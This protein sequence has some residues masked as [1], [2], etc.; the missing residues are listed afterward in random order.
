MVF[1]VVPPS[2]AARQIEGFDFRED[3]IEFSCW[4]RKP[5]EREEMEQ[6]REGQVEKEVGEVRE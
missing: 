1:E 2:P 4:R 3:S 5:G 6:E